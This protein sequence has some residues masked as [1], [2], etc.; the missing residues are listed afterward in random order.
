[1]TTTATN[2]WQARIEQRREHEV[3]PYVF[4]LVQH[5]HVPIEDV[6]P[7]LLLINCNQF[8]MQ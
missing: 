2:K 7:F 1:M 3:V 4:Q 8:K 5:N 6:A